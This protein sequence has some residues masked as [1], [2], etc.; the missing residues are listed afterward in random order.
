MT[1]ELGPRLARA[2]VFGPEGSRE[3]L[4][5]YARANPGPG[6]ERPRAFVTQLGDGQVSVKKVAPGGRFLFPE[7]DD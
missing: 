2:A 1:T 3:D 4:E 7:D 6:A 5:A